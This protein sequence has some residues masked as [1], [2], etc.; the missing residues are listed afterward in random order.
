MNRPNDPQQKIADCLT[1][2]I[3]YGGRKHEL[4]ERE[5]RALGYTKFCRRSLYTRN[6]RGRSDPGWI[7]RFGWKNKIMA[8]VAVATG[9]S[10]ARVAEPPALAGGKASSMS[11]AMARV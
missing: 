9:L 8:R 2:Y 10:N 11:D 6:Q 1:L 4:I 5:M 7:E 3:K